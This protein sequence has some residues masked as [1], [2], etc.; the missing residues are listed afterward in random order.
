MVEL[1]NKIFNLILT[2]RNVIMNIIINKVY[3]PHYH[4]IKIFNINFF[5]DLII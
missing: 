4:T 1:L 3:S 5:F 2:N